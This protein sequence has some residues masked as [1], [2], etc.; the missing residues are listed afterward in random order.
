MKGDR[1]KL[2]KVSAAFLG[3]VF[4]MQVAAGQQ[5]Y[6]SFPREQ[7]KTVDGLDATFRIGFVNLENYTRSIVLD[8]EESSSYS[9]EFEENPYSLEPSEVTSTPEDGD[10]YSVGDGRYAEIQE[11]EFTVE[12]DEEEA[13]KKQFS[14][15][16]QLAASYSGPD[17]GNAAIQRA[18]LAQTHVFEM[19]TTSQLIRP[20]AENLYNDGGLIGYE[21]NTSTSE[22][23]TTREEARN[24][25]NSTGQEDQET[26]APEKGLTRQEKDQSRAVNTWTL[27]FLAGTLISAFFLLRELF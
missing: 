10:W 27:I 19:E 9:V 5:G 24:V 3:L 2:V 1:E 14:I 6:G 18:F 25:E 8:A 22:N 7:S 4:M 15:P 13:E 23:G 12:L 11:V 21:E 26:A 20:R 17:G 16:I